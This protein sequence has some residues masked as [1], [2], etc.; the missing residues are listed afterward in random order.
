MRA[1]LRLLRA[2]RSKVLLKAYESKPEERCGRSRLTTLNGFVS[3]LFTDLIATTF[4]IHQGS[5]G[6]IGIAAAVYTQGV[7]GNVVRIIGC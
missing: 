5:E 3:D 4:A 2:S 7:S 6:L 1:R